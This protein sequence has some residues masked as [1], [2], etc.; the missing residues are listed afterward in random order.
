ML[1]RLTIWAWDKKHRCG[2]TYRHAVCVYGVRDL[3]F[4]KGRPELFANKFL[5]YLQ[6]LA[7]DCLEERHFRQIRDEYAGRR[8]FNS[9]YYAQMPF[10]KNHL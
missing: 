7:Y 4:L 8:L 2:G 9:S 3:S 10:A 6:P 5:P 1:S